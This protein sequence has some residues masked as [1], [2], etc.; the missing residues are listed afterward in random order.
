MKF[1]CQHC[2]RLI[3]GRPYQVLSEE[4]GIT[5]LDLIVCHSCYQEARELGLRGKEI[6]SM[7]SRARARRPQVIPVPA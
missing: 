5:L 2:D 1:L 4:N 7:K 3:T 6:K